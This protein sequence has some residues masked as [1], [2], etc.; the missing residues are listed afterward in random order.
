MLDRFD[1]KILAVWQ[2][3]GDI[4]PVEMSQEVNLSPSQCSR[5]M[6]QLRKSGFIKSFRAVLEPV[7]ISIGVSAYVLLTMKSHSPEA[8]KAIHDRVLEMDE[9]VQCQ[10]LTGAADLIVKV[11]TRDLTSFNRFLTDQL[12]SAPEIATAQSSIILEDVKNTSSLSLKFV[13]PK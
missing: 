7:K 10:K 13:V 5:R 6:Q 12:L 11:E 4:G 1:L 8:A 3:R 9:I 2:E